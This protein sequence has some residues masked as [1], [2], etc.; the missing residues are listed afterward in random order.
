MPTGE[1]GRGKVNEAE[2]HATEPEILS[3]LSAQDLHAAVVRED[4]DVCLTV[5]DGETGFEISTA[6][7]GRA[8][9]IAG[10]RRLAAT[11]AALTEELHRAQRHPG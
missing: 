11:A 3:T 4:D 9:A 2:T 8:L 10:L 6:I 5:H 1:S 7:G